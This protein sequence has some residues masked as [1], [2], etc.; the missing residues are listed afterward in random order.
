MADILK[1]VVLYIS[2]ANYSLVIKFCMQMRISVS[3]ID[4]DEKYFT[5]KIQDGG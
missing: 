1:I 2:D 4:C 3:G 5:F